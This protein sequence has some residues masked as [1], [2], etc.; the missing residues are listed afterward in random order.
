MVEKFFQAW[1]KLDLTSR[2][3]LILL[4]APE[5]PQ[6][7]LNR[8]AKKSWLSFEAKVLGNEIEKIMIKNK[9][10]N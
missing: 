1:G 8:M 4:A 9:L 5:F 3:A 2:K 10:L 6:K 7:A